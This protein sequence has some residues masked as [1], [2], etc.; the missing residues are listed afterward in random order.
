MLGRELAVMQAPMFD[1]DTFDIFVPPR[2]TLE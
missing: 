1:G 2:F